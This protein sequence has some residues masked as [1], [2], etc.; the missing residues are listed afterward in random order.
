VVSTRSLYICYLSL[1]DPLA[2]TQVVAYLAGLAE[3][4]HV[5]HLLTFE[6]EL[7]GPRRRELRAEMA[8]LGISWHG[9]RYHK[10][11]SLPATIYDTF[12]GAT[13]AWWLVVRHRLQL[14]HARSHVPLAMTMLA[15]PFT[16]SRIVFD[17][18][19]LLADEYADAGRWDRD[20][21]AYRITDWIQRVGLRRADGFVVLTER[22]R[23]QLW[24]ETPPATAHVIPCCADFDRLAASDIDVRAALGLGKRPIMIY[25]G[26]LTGVYMDREMADFFAVARSANP[27][28]AFMILTQS[29]A[30]SIVDELRRAGIPERD[31][32][33]A[34]AASQEVGAY[35]AAADFAICFCHPK[36]SLIAA[37]PTKIGEYLAAGLPV[38]S[39]PD[40]GDTD[41]ILRDERVGAIVP[42][43]G[44]DAY[45]RAAAEMLRLAADDDARERCREVAR[46]RFSLTGVGIP[47]YDALYRQI[48]AMVGPAPED[49]AGT[50]LAAKP[51]SSG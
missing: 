5:I 16:R 12:A 50:S 24:G 40:V 51:P 1:T 35:L 29:S 8:Q 23:R 14:L 25:V 47:R 31:Y 19:G 26:K 15:R 22:V 6:T 36:P 17:I 3:R 44:E 7:N 38:V 41:A 21:A 2:R 46:R 32:R 37:S 42:D 10:R 34:T 18:R 28:L 20:G 39:G 9:L 13:V 27:D 11:P 43:F 45:E 30:E 48:A 4:G 49:G 33:I